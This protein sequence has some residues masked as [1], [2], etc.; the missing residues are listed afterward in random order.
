[1]G[2][3]IYNVSYNFPSNCSKNKKVSTRISRS[4]TCIPMLY[5]QMFM[6]MKRAFGYF[7]RSAVRIK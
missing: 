4:I 6:N 5:K 2:K 7:Q 1:M 3:L